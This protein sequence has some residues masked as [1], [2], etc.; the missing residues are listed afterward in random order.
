MTEY[1]SP[2]EATFELQRKS[3]EQG[4]QV[5]EQGIDLQREFS[6]SLV[7]SL[8]SQESFQRRLVELNRDTI[9]SVVEAVEDVP[10]V[11]SVDTDRDVLTVTTEGASKTD[12]LDAVE[13]AGGEV[14]DFATREASL[15][16]VFAA[17]TNDRD[18][19]VSA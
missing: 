12:V 9:Q 18:D 16:D 5:V 6:Q 7:D 14:V 19:E 3:I 13:A 8:E 15:D 17:Y 11:T 4:Q 1:T 2:I 10:G